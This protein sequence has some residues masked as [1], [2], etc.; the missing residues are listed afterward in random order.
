MY[1]VPSELV[2]LLKV[3][4]VPV[5]TTVIFAPGSTE[6][7]G[8][9]TAPSIVAVPVVWASALVAMKPS[10]NRVRRRCLD[11]LEAGIYHYGPRVVNRAGQRDEKP[12]ASSNAAKTVLILAGETIGANTS[13]NGYCLPPCSMSFGVRLAQSSRLVSSLI[14]APSGESPH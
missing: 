10:A 5:C 13:T 3:K 9:V 1:Q 6:P 11:L 2:R 4:F 12:S 8:S 14:S 7:V